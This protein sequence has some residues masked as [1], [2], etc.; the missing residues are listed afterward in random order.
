M[1]GILVTG[2]EPIASASKSV[3]VLKE[4]G[5][6]MSSCSL[7]QLPE[8]RRYHTQTGL[9]VCGGGLDSDS[10]DIKRT[11]VTLTNGSW[12]T[13]HNLVHPRGGHTSWASP[14]GIIFFGGLYS[15]DTAEVLKEDG[16]SEEIFKLKHIFP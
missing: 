1:S 5:S 4:D 8:S 13:S 7:P 9:T 15:Q 3:E 12:R 16:T 10:D 2:G 14:I 6:Q 11:C